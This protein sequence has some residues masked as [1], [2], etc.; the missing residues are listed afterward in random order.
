MESF[1][2]DKIYIEYLKEREVH[3]FS[4]PSDQGSVIDANILNFKKDIFDLNLPSQVEETTNL[5]SS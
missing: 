2:L 1:D 4:V 3:C 5:F